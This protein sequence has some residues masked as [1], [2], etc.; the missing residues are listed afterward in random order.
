M[1]LFSSSQRLGKASDVSGAVLFVSWTGEKDGFC[2]INYSKYRKITVFPNF[3]L[4]YM[5]TT[6]FFQLTVLHNSRS[7][8][9]TWQLQ[10]L[11]STWLVLQE[12]KYH[13]V[14][15]LL[16]ISQSSISKASEVFLLNERPLHVIK[17]QQAEL[18]CA[19]L[20]KKVRMF[21]IH[22][23]RKVEGLPLN[24]APE[25]WLLAAGTLQLHCCWHL[26]EIRIWKAHT[27]LLEC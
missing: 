7:L 9:T 5:T 10:W 11:T 1:I 21:W 24:A 15:F 17:Y 16:Q 12:V 14:A 22:L 25:S 13:K 27:F 8:S 6:R 26:T 18:R 2:E 19:T 20:T 23:T 3:N 4:K